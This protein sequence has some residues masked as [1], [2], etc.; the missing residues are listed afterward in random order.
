MSN[1]LRLAL[2]AA[3]DQTR[4]Q[5]KALL[6][7][8]GSVWLEA[9][10]SRFE[11]FPAVVEQTLPDVG[12][13]ALDSDPEQALGLVEQLTR[14]HP[15][16]VLLVVSAS[17]DGHLIL[18]SIRAGA[19]EFLTL[20]LSV[21]DLHGALD[22]ISVQKFGSGELRK[23]TCE[24]IAFAGAT[25]G[26]G[27]TSIAS[28]I[29]CFLARGG[30]RSTA[31][32]DLDMALGDADVFLNVIPDYT[33]A[34]VVQNASQLDMQLLKKSLT[35]HASGLY[36]LPRPVDLSD[37][38]A[39][40]EETVRRV[41]GLMRTSFT[42][43][44]VD[45]SKTYSP[46]DM[47]AMEMATKVVLVTQLDLPCL[48]NVVRL[49]MSFEEIENLSGKVEI[50]VNRAGLDS[51]QISLKKAKETLGR[52]IFGLVP[53]DYRTMVSVRNNGV[54]L[55]TQA[56]KAPITLAVQDLAQRLV[57]DQQPVGD[58]ASQEPETVES[59]WSKFWPVGGKSK[60]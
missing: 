32:M 7:E 11:F 23:T 54:P 44:V 55:M 52:E 46:V 30:G 49:L 45:L 18:K 56:P 1:I 33:L 47:A 4:E 60:R 13:I 3:D 25:G 12:V 51:G 50:V 9:D 8:L 22:R 27:C 48:R 10:C 19:R 26:V 16:C 15:D 37:A 5:L 20:P 42:H 58:D 36:L 57:A 41:I 24:V 2:V 39:I 31:L 35:K 28:N 29:G 43:M 17:T 34:D 14:T 38:I 40:D 59:R 53:N 21:D 6:L